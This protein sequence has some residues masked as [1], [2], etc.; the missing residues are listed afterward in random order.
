ME[1]RTESKLESLGKFLK[2]YDLRLG[3]VPCG[4]CG[5]NILVNIPIVS[6]SFAGLKGIPCC[7]E[8]YTPYSLVSTCQEINDNINNFMASELKLDIEDHEEYYDNEDD[9]EEYENEEYND[10]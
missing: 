10:E 7:G 3:L 8:E 1:E 6:E 4:C 9:F 5:K 2:K